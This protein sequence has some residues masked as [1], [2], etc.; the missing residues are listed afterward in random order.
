[1]CIKISLRGVIKRF[2]H[3]AIMLRVTNND[4]IFTWIL[5]WVGKVSAASAAVPTLASAASAT[6]APAQLSAA[7]PAGL[8]HDSWCVGLLLP[9]DDA[10]DAPAS[11]GRHAKDHAA[12]LMLD[13]TG[14]VLVG[15]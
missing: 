14:D 15:G 5:I 4:D 10:V 13:E 11:S 2:E 6:A 8:S 3:F 1:M 7:D 12:N 9:R